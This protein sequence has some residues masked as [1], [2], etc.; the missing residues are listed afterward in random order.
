MA[1]SGVAE[2]ITISSYDITDAMVSGWG[3]WAHTY[4]GTITPIGVFDGSAVADYSGGSGTLND[5]IIGTSASD[6]QL[7]EQGQT[8]QPVITLFLPGLYTIGSI[9][10]YGGPT[11]N[12]YP[13]VITGVTVGIG[14]S[15]SAISLSPFGPRAASGQPINDFATIIGTSLQGIPTTTITLSNFTG[16]VFEGHFSITEIQIDSEIFVPAPEPADIWLIGSGL[17]GLLAVSVMRKPRVAI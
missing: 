14:A 11:N 9:I 10:L 2:P 6:T 15:S 16:T 5:D 1:I 12:I 7:F 13:G 8:V 17:L 3:L 4:S